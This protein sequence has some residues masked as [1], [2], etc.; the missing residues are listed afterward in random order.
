MRAMTTRVM[1]ETVRQAVNRSAI[2][3]GVLGVVLSPIPLADEIAF[4]PVLAVLA[5]RIGKS[6][7]LGFRQV[8]WRPIAKT[9]VAALTA[10]AALN[11]AVS[12]IP[13]VAAVANA[14][15]AVTT[16]KLLGRYM[17]DACADP[18]SAHPMSIAEVTGLLKEALTFR[19]PPQPV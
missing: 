16:T 11:L 5:T 17:D 7:G 2:V 13:G 4:V 14:V 6:H 19:R 8:P 9:T 15:S 10:R 1:D 18:A 3:A 12:Y